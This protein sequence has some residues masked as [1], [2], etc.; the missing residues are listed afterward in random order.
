[1]AEPSNAAEAKT[2]SLIVVERAHMWKLTEMLCSAKCS[3]PLLVEYLESPTLSR[4]IVAPSLTRLVLPS[5]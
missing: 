4:H 1:M 3:A 2:G 5:P